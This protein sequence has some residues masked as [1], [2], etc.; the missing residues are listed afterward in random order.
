MSKPIHIIATRSAQH[1]YN[2]W[3]TTQRQAIRSVTDVIGD[4]RMFEGERLDYVALCYDLDA[5][6]YRVIATAY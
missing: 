2:L 4:A 6:E 1:A 5:S 3:R